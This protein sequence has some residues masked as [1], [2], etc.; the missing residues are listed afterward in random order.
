MK[1]DELI[2]RLTSAGRT[3]PRHGSRHD[4]YINP[5]TGQKQPVPRHQEIDETLARHIQKYLG[6]E[7]G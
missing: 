3:L 5:G 6:M 2:R 1:R 7:R 4:I